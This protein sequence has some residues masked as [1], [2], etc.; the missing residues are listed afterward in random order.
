[1]KLNRK[2]V[3]ILSLALSLALATGGTMAYLAD[4]NADVNTMTLGNVHIVQNV[5]ER[6]AT[7]KLVS[8]TQD[9]PLYPAVYPGGQIAWARP[10][11][12]PVPNDANWAVL[13]DNPLVVDKFVTVTN[14]G[15]SAA[16]LRTL[17]AV[18]STANPAEDGEF[19]YVVC[20]AGVSAGEDVMSDWTWLTDT[21]SLKVDDKY[22]HIAYV[23]YLT[24]LQPGATS[25]PSLKQ[26][27]M[28]KDA[29]NDFV[30]KLGDKYDVLV[31]SQA[32]QAD[33]FDDAEKA[34][35]AAFGEVN[36]DNAAAWFGGEAIRD[37][38]SPGKDWPDNNPPVIITP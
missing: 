31:L 33:G 25:L 27:Y 13:A 14:T 23:T 1:M 10:N 19:I 12:W 9:K 16:Y 24:P 22:F 29:T 18:E 26:I 35:N 32:V 20:N 28:G 4:S 21:E 30:G 5:Q 15:N 2:L 8:F 11:Q 36:L 17:V 6:D 7:G 34:L 38:G 3:L 37:V